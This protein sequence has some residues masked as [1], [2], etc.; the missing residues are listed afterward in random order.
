MTRTLAR[1][2]LLAA[3]VAAPLAATAGDPAPL[4]ERYQFLAKGKVR[5]T[6]AWG[7]PE[8]RVILPARVAF[9]ADGK[10]A[11]V[12]SAEFG[13]KDAD[14]YV[15][16]LDV[17]TATARRVLPIKKA[18]ATCLALSADSKTAAAA[19]FAGDQV[20]GTVTVGAWDTTTGKPIRELV[21]A[22][23]AT[24][25]IVAITLAPEGAVA[26]T[27][28]LTGTV[29]VWDLKNGQLLHNLNDHKGGATCVALSADGT[30]ALSGGND[31]IVRLWSLKTG[32]EVQSLSAKQG[33]LTTV[34]FLPGDNTRVLAIG[35]DQEV[36]L[37]DIT[38]NKELRRFKKDPPANGQAPLTLSAD[39]KKLFLLRSPYIQAKNVIEHFVTAWETDTGKELWTS[40][41]ELKIPTPLHLSADGKT[42]LLGGGESQL[43]TLDA[44]NGKELRVWGGHRGAVVQAAIEPKTGRLWTASQDRTVKCWPAAGGAET[45]TLQG[46]DDVVTG[47]AVV[48][49]HLLTASNDKTM[50][51]WKLGTATM[52]RE[53]KGH[54]AGITGLAVSRDGKR[55]VTGSGDRSVKLWDLST[56]KELK[57]F[58]GHSHAI[59]CVALSP[60]GKWAASGSEDKTVRLWYIADDGKDLEPVVLEGHDKDVTAVAFLPDGRHVLSASQDKTLILW[61]IEEGKAVKKLKGH[62]NWITSLAL[63]RDGK[64]AVTTCD[65]LTVK[66][67]D[68]EK[69]TEIASLDLGAAGDVAKCAALL[70]DEAGFVVGTANWLVLRFEWEKK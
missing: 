30:F 69:G 58:T 23:E 47:L 41:V 10:T 54:T 50:K 55:A 40:R 67:W 52:V 8:Q 31:G 62:T 14:D 3:A 35:Q 61:D 9:A 49:E 70:P 65:D 60:D 16:V 26:A 28:S 18:V 66:V 24:Q 21:V 38:N 2:L 15:T 45:F 36:V 17:A 7:T 39:G 51:L 13:E 37:W 20:K 32:K 57:S 29:Q 68:V 34:A 19:T 11:L 27:A 42:L 12:A 63:T 44:A 33:A 4:P 6:R 59:T 56:G 1:W 46:H 22:K 48:G 64:R 5:L 25:P 53:F 43:M